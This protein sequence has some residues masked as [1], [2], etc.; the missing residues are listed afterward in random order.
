VNKLTRDDIV[1][2]LKIAI[3]IALIIVAIKFF[4]NMLPL[5]ILLLIIV[6]LV[7][8]FMKSDYMKEKRK[9]KAEKNKVMDAEIIEE[10]QK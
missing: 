3:S 8:S 2:F 4:I 5:I 1:L 7:D 9:E 6:L 10:K